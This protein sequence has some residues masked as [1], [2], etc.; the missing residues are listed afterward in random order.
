MEYR[1]FG[2]TNMML[3]T[4]GLGGLLAHYEGVSGHPPPEE[5]LGG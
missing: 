5:K 1:K 2:Q 3:S 4:V